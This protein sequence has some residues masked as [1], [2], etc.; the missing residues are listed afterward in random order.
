[1]YFIKLISC[2]LVGTENVLWN[3]DGVHIIVCY[4]R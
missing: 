1:M 3:C 2:F 4:A